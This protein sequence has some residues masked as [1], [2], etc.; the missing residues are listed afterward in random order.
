VHADVKHIGRR[1]TVALETMTIVSTGA[2]SWQ[3]RLGVKR[4]ADAHSSQ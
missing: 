2:K 3:H 4:I 1:S